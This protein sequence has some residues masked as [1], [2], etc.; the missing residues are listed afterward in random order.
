MLYSIG[1]DG[2]VEIVAV[3]YLE[4]FVQLRGRLSEEQFDSIRNEIGRKIDGLDR[5]T[6]S[7]I[8]GGDWKESPFLVIREV[9]CQGNHQ[10]AGK[11]FGLI[12]WHHMMEHA[13][14]W[15]FQ[16]VEQK[17]DGEE[18]GK[19]YFRIKIAR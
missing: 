8:G 12:V 3:P 5:F 10:L 18:G 17:L 16:E 4:S 1:R 9:A 11:F 19:L 14:A 13:D 15:S 7:Q 2:P 6:S